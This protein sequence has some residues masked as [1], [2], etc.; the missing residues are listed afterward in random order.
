MNPI[1]QATIAAAVT[2]Q[3]TITATTSDFTDL[4]AISYVPPIA[5]EDEASITR[6]S[7]QDSPFRIGYLRSIMLDEF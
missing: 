1:I 4:D 5:T 6:V 3:S 7:Y 2:A